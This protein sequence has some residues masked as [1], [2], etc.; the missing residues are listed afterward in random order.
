MVANGDQLRQQC[1]GFSEIKRIEAFGKPTLQ[2]AVEGGL[3]SSPTKVQMSA[4]E[5]GPFG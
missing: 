1:F 2:T 5:R 4:I 3:Q